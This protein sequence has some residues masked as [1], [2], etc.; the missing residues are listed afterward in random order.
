MRNYAIR[1]NVSLLLLLWALGACST[2]TALESG[3]GV[4]VPGLMLGPGDEIEIKFYNVSELD[5]MQTVRYD[6]KISLFLV[7][8]VYVEGKTVP[9]VRDT[10]MSLYSDHLNNPDILVLQRNNFNRI[11]T[12]CKK[13]I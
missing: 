10:L 6:G 5:E 4:E 1:V 12:L 9:Q 11:S 8:D 3:T 7:G 13:Q 2:R